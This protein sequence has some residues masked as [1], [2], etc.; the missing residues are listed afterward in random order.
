MAL[1]LNDYAS[2]NVNLIWNG[3]PLIGTTDSFVTVAYEEDQI[4]MKQGPDGS[5]STSL[6]PATM[7]TIEVTLQQESPTHIALL[8]VLNQQKRSRQLKRGTFLISV[9]GS[10]TPLYTGIN[11]VIMNPPDVTYGKTH[12]DGERTWTFKASELKLGVI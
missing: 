7:G 11:T 9:L 8:A 3:I 5:I 10:G 12:E 6:L 1:I 2:Q 4:D